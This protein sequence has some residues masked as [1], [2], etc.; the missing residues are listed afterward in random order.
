MATTS[1][2]AYLGFDGHCAEALRFYE[3]ALG[4]KIQFM[5]TYGEAPDAAQMPAEHR[6]RI[7]HATLTLPGG[8]QLYA[9]DNPP[10]T[11][12]PAT[13][14]GVGLM[15]DIDDVAAGEKA[16]NALAEGGTVTMP[17]AQTFWAERFGMVTDRYGVGWMVNAG[18]QAM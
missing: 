3:K 6:G 9:A 8:G 2:T 1:L 15:I 4:G 18:Q 13:F 17:F 16:F 5:L 14:N 10:G 7:M 12:G 11:P